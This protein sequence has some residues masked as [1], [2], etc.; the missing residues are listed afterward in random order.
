MDGI[1]SVFTPVVSYLGKMAKTNL[2]SMPKC[3]GEE[4]DFG[5]DEYEGKTK[6]KLIRKFYLSGKICTLL[7]SSNFKK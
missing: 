1:N 4:D 3:E 2:P 6:I 5:F 7:K